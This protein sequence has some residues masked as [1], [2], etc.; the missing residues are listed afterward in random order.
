ME[1][2]GFSEKELLVRNVSSGTKERK[3]IPHL[4]KI[5]DLTLLPETIF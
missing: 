5:L 4:T 1:V 3:N 2:P